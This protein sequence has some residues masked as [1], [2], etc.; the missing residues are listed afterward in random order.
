M[1]HDFPFRAKAAEI[2][3]EFPFSIGDKVI[4][5]GAEHVML[6]NIAVADKHPNFPTYNEPAV[7]IVTGLW[8]EMCHGGIQQ[9]ISVSF[10]VDGKTAWLRPE[11][12]RHFVTSVDGNP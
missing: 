5:A 10:G 11:Q 1:T 2:M 6:R 7:G 8:L 9:H 3:S 4:H 12:L